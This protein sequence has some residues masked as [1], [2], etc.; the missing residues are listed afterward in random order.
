MCVCVCVCVCVC[1]CACVRTRARLS[2]RVRV[3]ECDQQ[4]SLE[5]LLSNR[6]SLVCL[7]FMSLCDQFDHQKLSRGR[8]RQPASSESIRLKCFRL[9]VSHRIAH[10]EGKDGWTDC[11]IRQRA[12]VSV[13]LFVSECS[14]SASPCPCDW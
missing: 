12:S 7:R 2:V 3:C 6:E 11:E 13:Q 8:H 10:N 5:R 14:L 1:A 9:K 4:S